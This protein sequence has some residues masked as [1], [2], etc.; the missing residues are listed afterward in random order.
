MTAPAPAPTERDLVE[1]WF[2]SRRAVTRTED[3]RTLR[4][5]YP[6]V[7]GGGA[8][9]DIRDAAL[10]IG[11][12]PLRGDVEVHLRARG[13]EEHGHAADP[14]YAGVVLHL[15]GENDAG[16][17]VT[18]HGGGRHIPI[19]VATLG[20]RVRQGPLFAPPCTRAPAG[21]LAA[22]LDGLGW[23]RLEEKAARVAP[24]VARYGAPQALYAAIMATLGGTLNRA[25]FEALAWRMPL[26]PAL[27]RAAFAPGDRASAIHAAWV[28]VAGGLRFQQAGCRPA[29]RPAVRL[30]AGASLVARLWPDPDAAWPAAL[31]ADG[32]L[33][34]ALRSPGIGEGLAA[35]LTVN[36]VLPVAIADD[37]WPGAAVRALLSR[38]RAPAPYG[39]LE[40]LDGWLTRDGVRPFRTAAALQGGLALH[41]GHCARGR[42]GACPLSGL[43]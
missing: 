1:R 8:G 27:E 21:H 2:R 17:L 35:E 19:A 40:R 41:A 33:P 15:V 32:A 7:P 29:A 5:L 14:A 16:A 38:L 23:R 6:G 12:D 9:P 36:A 3:G 24:V 34:G 28:S 25:P 42:C 39:R 11:G 18:R 4:V 26:A 31:A 30:P 43:R 10:E 13:W 20:P 37:R 22:V